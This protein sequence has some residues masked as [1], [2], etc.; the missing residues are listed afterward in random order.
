MLLTQVQNMGLQVGRCALLGSPPPRE[1]LQPGHPITLIESMGPEKGSVGHVKTVFP[2]GEVGVNFPGLGYYEVPRTALRLGW[3]GVPES[4]DEEVTLVGGTAE[5]AK[6]KSQHPADLK[7]RGVKA[8]LYLIPWAVIPDRHVP[9]PLTQAAISSGFWPDGD[10]Y[11]DELGGT[12]TAQGR[13]VFD[14]LDRLLE[15]VDLEDVARV[16][17][18]G[19]KKYARDNWR[20]FSWDARAQDEYLGAI[21]RHLNDEEDRAEDSGCCHWAHAAAGCMIILWHLNRVS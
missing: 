19:A 10:A 20:A 14:L 15:S 11:V 18:F 12:D 16:F 7:P 8:P 6:D 5:V 13:F 4:T 1:G 17:E 21:Y 9:V 3:D 2:D